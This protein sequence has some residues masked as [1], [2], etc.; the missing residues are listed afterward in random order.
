MD[1]S[2]LDPCANSPCEEGLECDLN[3]AGQPICVCMKQCPN[4]S[5][6]KVRRTT[7]WSV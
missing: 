7:D 1:L 4:D 6:I 5:P 3:D 2:L